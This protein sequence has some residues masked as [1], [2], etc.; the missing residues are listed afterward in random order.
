RRDDCLAGEFHEGRDCQDAT[1]CEIVQPPQDGACCVQGRC[2]VASHA[3]CNAQG[4]DY[5]GDGVSCDVVR[6]APPEEQ[7]ACCGA[8]GRNQT[9]EAECAD[10]AWHVG[11]TCTT[12]G[13]CAPEEI[14]CC[15]ASLTC[16]LMP[17][18][19]CLAGGGSVAGV[20]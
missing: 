7:G 5:H 9:T 12:A 16:S 1:L 6:C 2:D 18:D 3:A 20:A 11:E 13:I 8:N 19:Q 10:G 17:E 4:G 14:A 15:D